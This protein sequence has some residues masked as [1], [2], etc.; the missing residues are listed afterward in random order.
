M[1]K[2]EDHMTEACAAELRRRGHKGK[3]IKEWMAVRG[4]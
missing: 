3:L 4:N 1:S 2:L